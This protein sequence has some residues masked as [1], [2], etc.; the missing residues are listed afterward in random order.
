MV[1]ALVTLVDFVCFLVQ[2]PEHL[3]KDEKIRNWEQIKTIVPDTIRHSTMGQ[4]LGY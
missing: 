4:L 1:L 2:I 3:T